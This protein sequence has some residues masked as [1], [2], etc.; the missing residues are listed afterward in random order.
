MALEPGTRL[1]PF[2]IITLLGSVGM[3]K[4]L[5]RELSLARRDTLG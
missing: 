5:L 2:E 3:G 4:K 1:G